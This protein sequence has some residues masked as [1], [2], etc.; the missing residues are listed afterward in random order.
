MALRHVSATYTLPAPL[1]VD[2]YPDLHP[3]PT[4][5]RI[6]LVPRRQYP[7]RICLY[8]HQNPLPG[9]LI[10]WLLVLS[11]LVCMCEHHVGVPAVHQHPGCLLDGVP[12]AGGRANSSGDSWWKLTNLLTDATAAATNAGGR[13]NRRGDSWWQLMSETHYF[14]L[15]CPFLVA[16]LAAVPPSA[17][18]HH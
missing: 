12:D 9:R 8:V 7:R 6:H 1:P 10:F 13:A 3:L 18:I 15:W 4:L 11:T 2:T 14:L 5:I 17:G 16:K